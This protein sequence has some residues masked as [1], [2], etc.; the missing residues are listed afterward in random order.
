MTD[1][2]MPLDCTVAEQ[3]AM[4]LARAAI[5]GDSDGSRPRDP[6]V[7]R[8]MTSTQ[9]VL[10]TCHIIGWRGAMHESAHIRA[11]R[12][13]YQAAYENAITLLSAR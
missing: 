7:M 11:I 6:N 4:A 1:P 8:G 13:A 3:F 12:Y 2:L 10:K 9:D 5:M